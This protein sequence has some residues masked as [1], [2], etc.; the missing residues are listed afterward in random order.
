L[1]VHKPA[2]PP[3]ALQPPRCPNQ[4]NVQ[5]KPVPSEQFGFC[6][7]VLFTA[8]RRLLHRVKQKG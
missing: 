5:H 1:A 4:N 7:A 3:R 8:Y 2:K 6:Q